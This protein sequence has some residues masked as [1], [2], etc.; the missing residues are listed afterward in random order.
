MVYIDFFALCVMVLY[1]RYGLL[2]NSNEHLEGIW[3]WIKSSNIKFYCL[4]LIVFAIAFLAIRLVPIKKRM[5]RW[6]PLTEKVGVV[7]V[8][9]IAGAGRLHWLMTDQ[10][11]E[12]GNWEWQGFPIVAEPFGTI[13]V[14]IAVSVVFLVLLF[15]ACFMPMCLQ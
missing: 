4:M 11:N 8:S 2:M 14:L 3:G 12:Y 1:T 6:S 9:G 13:M 7:I 15:P 10:L 5:D